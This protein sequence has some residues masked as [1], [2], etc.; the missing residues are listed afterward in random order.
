MLLAWLANNYW[1][2]NFVADQGGR[3]RFR[4]WLLPGERRP[5]GV[6][7]QEA[8]T[9]AHPPAAHVY[10]ERGPVREAS[11][12]LLRTDLGPLLLTRLEQEGTGV[13]LTLLNPGAEASEARIG[14]GLI[15]PGRARRTSLSG[16][17]LGDLPI[18]GGEVRVPVGPRAWTRVVIQP[19]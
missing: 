1:M 8:V 19:A 15:R 10:A 7:A 11:A 13:A 14:A 4:F 9:Y 3:L 5:L 18:A 2:T 12:T 17:P 6:A 16:E